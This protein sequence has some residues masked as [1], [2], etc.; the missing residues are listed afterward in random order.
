MFL[1]CDNKK[2]ISEYFFKLG[3]VWLLLLLTNCA[4][5]PSSNKKV[6]SDCESK[7]MMSEIIQCFKNN[8]RQ[9]IT[10]RID[11]AT[12]HMTA[13]DWPYSFQ[14][15]IQLKIE[16]TGKFAI[17][18]VLNS[19]KSRVLNKKVKQSIEGIVEFSVPKNPLFESVH[20]STLKLL[21]KPA[22]TP[23]IGKENLIDED[24]LVIYIHKLK[25]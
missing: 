23:L 12:R 24:A 13:G 8:I 3:F 25:R 6:Q 18:S 2:P 17:K 15:L 20:F 1:R 7:L 11:V 19:S 22:R 21:I 5:L 16:K 10:R 14:I 4:S 9:R